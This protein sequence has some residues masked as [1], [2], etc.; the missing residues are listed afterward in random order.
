M[1]SRRLSQHQI[2]RLSKFKEQTVC[3]KGTG[4]DGDAIPWSTPLVE[5]IALSM[6]TCLSFYTSEQSLSD[7]FSNLAKLLKV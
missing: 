5:Q 3:T 1:V 2:C 7:A 6:S 4:K